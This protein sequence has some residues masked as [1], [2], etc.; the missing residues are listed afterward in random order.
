M[1]LTYLMYVDQYHMLGLRVFDVH[2]W[3]GW[4]SIKL[5]YNLKMALC[6]LLSNSWYLHI[7]DPNISL[8]GSSWNVV[9]LNMESI[10]FTWAPSSM[11]NE[12]T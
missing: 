9:A 2:P 10:G 6:F 11:M 12:K 4:K 8:A 5:L 7:R 1:L 3:E